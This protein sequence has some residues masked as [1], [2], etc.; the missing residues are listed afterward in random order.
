MS[1]I[2][3]CSCYKK[4]VTENYKGADLVFTGK[5]VE[6]IEQKVIDSIPTDNKLNPFKIR[7]YNRVEFKFKII[8]LYKGETDSE[9]V[10]IYTTG[11]ISDCGNYFQLNSKQLVYSYIKDRRLN[12]WSTKRKVKPYLS[13]STC[14]QT[15]KLRRVKRKEKRKLT[16]LSGIK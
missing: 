14:S 11:G 6:V 8:K 2:C 7:R 15:K 9:F 5:V 13:T 10:S 16:K 4:S 1:E 12:D 3:A